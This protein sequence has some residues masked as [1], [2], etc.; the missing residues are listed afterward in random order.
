[1]TSEAFK[2]TFLIGLAYEIA[3]AVALRL[4]GRNVAGPFVCLG[5]AFHKVKAA[6]FGRQYWPVPF[7]QEAFDQFAIFHQP[8]VRTVA[9]MIAAHTNRPQK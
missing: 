9:S 3:Y 5:L 4:R 7:W 8:S 2:F 6:V 1:M